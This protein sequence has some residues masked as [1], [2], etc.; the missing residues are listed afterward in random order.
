MSD[1]VARAPGLKVRRRGSKVDYYWVASN[2][3]RHAA[4]YPI[5]TVRLTEPTHEERAARCAILTA[6]LEEWLSGVVRDV[7]FDGTLRSLIR[8]YQTDPE[9]PYHKVKWN[10]RAHYDDTLELLERGFGARRLIDLTG[11]DFIRWYAEIKTPAEEGGPERVR[12]AHNCIKV[13]RIVTNYGAA[14][15]YARCAEIA[16]MLSRLRFAMPPPRKV[17]MT[18]EQARAIITRAIEMGR[19][20][21]ALA[22]ALQFELSLRQRDVIGEW[23]RVDGIGG[24]G[25]LPGRRWTGGATWTDISPDLILRK[26]TTKTGALGEWNLRLYP[27]VLLALRAYEPLTGRTGPLVVDE[28]AERP[29]THRHFYRLW[30]AIADAAGVPSTVWS[31]DSRAGGITEGGDAG[32]TIEDLR[33]HA[34]HTNAAMTTKYVRGTL[35]STSRVAELRTARRKQD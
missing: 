10:T 25:G 29:Y 24:I 16:G 3:S 28:T 35:P 5:K 9:S 22:Q 33:K 23:A 18:F 12:R 15:G 27:L 4:D 21:I 1:T 11:K 13:L 6:E 30:R 32:A 34:T 20:S 14:V 19:P 7:S 2:V 31:M 8:C 26:A 17:A